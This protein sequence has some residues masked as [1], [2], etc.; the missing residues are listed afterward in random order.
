MR[1]LSGRSASWRNAVVFAV[2]GFVVGMGWCYGAG[3]IGSHSEDAYIGRMEIFGNPTIAFHGGV[4][5]GL[6][7]ALQHRKIV[8][9]IGWQDLQFVLLVPVLS[10]FFVAVSLATLLMVPNWD[11][12]IA[13]LAVGT[14]I[15]VVYDYWP[16]MLIGSVATLCV[17]KLF[18]SWISRVKMQPEP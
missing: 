11:F 14:A 3:A 13:F 17:C 5:I 1:L 18:V 6:A 16:M 7:T 8:S 12:G 9:Q 15:F 2:I 10:A 4:A